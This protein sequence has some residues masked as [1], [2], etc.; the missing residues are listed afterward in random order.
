MPA[1]AHFAQENFH[2]NK[3]DSSGKYI[4]TN[5]FGLFYGISWT[6]LNNILASHKPLALVNAYGKQ[7]Y[8]FGL[9]SSDG[10]T[11]Y[12]YRQALLTDFSLPE[13]TKQSN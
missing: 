5:L 10:F 1:L 2:F 3:S 7:G 4:N 13:H 8:R 11:A 12:L 6:Y 9:F